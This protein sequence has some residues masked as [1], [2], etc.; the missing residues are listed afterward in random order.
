MTTDGDK[1]HPESHWLSRCP[2]DLVKNFCLVLCTIT[3]C[4]CLLRLTFTQ[5]VK[6]RLPPRILFEIIGHMLRE[7][8]VSSIP[9]IHHPL[10]NVDTSASNVRL[11]I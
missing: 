5:I 10:G 9:T 11:L 8:D 6:K 1:A 3:I 7:Q 4:V 2:R